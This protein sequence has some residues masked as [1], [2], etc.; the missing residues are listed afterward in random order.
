MRVKVKCIILFLI[1]VYSYGQIHKEDSIINLSNKPK[2]NTP[3]VLNK[4]KT[5]KSLPQNFKNVN[6]V[7]KLYSNDSL[8]FATQK[9]ILELEIDN[10][11]AWKR[12]YLIA[13]VSLFLLG[14]ISVYFIQRFYKRKSN[15]NNQ[16]P[17]THEIELKECINILLV[18]IDNLEKLIKKN[19]ASSKT[20][21]NTKKLHDLIAGKILTKE[22]WYSFKEKFN[23]VYPLFF[24]KIKEKGIKLT[25]SEERLVSL[26]KLGLDNNQIAKVLGISLDS[27]FVN[28]YRI[29]KKVNA[30]KGITILEF[31]EKNSWQ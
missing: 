24:N 3:S 26:E 12:I 13:S 6:D 15:R 14:V 27:V 16:I 29:R 9:R 18:K 7:E 5:L 4:N 30:P 23:Q 10:Q 25:N 21:D 11:K 17:S 31:L 8:K 22:D 1:V 2:E 19:K 20:N 28:R